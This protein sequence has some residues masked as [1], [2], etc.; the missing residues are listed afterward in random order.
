MVK[1]DQFSVLWEWH[2][3]ATA[4]FAAKESGFA[5]FKNDY[6]I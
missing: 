1:I 5:R 4:M 6:R 3:F 2:Y